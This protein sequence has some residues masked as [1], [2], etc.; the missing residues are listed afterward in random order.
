[1]RQK[2]ILA[3]QSQARAMLMSQAGIHFNAE[4]PKVD[5]LDIKTAF[6]E[7]SAEDTAL[8]LARAKANAVSSRHPGNLVLGCDQVLVIDGRIMDKPNDIEEAREHLELLRNQ[9][10]SLLSALVIVQDG[11]ETW[12]TLQE[13]HLTMRD[14][15][16]AFLNLYVTQLGTELCETV[17]GYKIEGLGAQLF[18]EIDG[19]YTTILGLP[20]FPLMAYLRAQKVLRE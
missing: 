6:R 9:Q 19:E 11:V 16:Q 2:V 13:A 7:R 4:D 15:S 17:G 12:N 8:E 3:S 14:F 10:H 18:E 5:E 1:M 20:I